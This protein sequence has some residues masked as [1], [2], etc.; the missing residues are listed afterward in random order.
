MGGVKRVTVLDGIPDGRYAPFEAAFLQEADRR[1][2]ALRVDFFRLRDLDIHFCTGCFTCWTRTPGLCAF[3][4]DMGPIL[5]SVLASDL[6][7]FLSPVSMGFVSS[8]IKKACDRM[9]PIVMPDFLVC[10][11]EFHHKA[12]YPS[13]PALGLMLL[14]PD[15]D[16]T[17]LRTVSDVFARTALN[18]KTELV[19][20]ES[21]RATP[22]EAIDAVSRL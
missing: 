1:A 7:V 19:L 6:C 20:S 5:Q 21:W 11:G 22:E 3:R 10:G 12:R 8:L 17:T 9:I 16:S 4:D 2:G 14:D 15:R 13:Y 18:L